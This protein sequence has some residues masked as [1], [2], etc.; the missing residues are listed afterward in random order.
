MEILSN[1]A[2]PYCCLEQGGNSSFAASETRVASISESQ[3]LDMLLVT[4]EG[5]KVTLS[6]D[7]STAA[8]YGEHGQIEAS[9]DG[10][11]VQWTELSTGQYERELQLSIEGDLNDQERCE[12]RKAIQTLGRMLCNFT[13][14]KVRPMESLAHSLGGLETIAQLDV[15][16]AYEQQVLVARQT[17]MAVAYG[18]LGEGIYQPALPVEEAVQAP[19]QNE[20]ED[21]AKEAV[22]A[23]MQIETEN[24]AKAGIQVALQA[25]TK[26]LAKEMAKVVRAVDAPWKDMIRMTKCLF[27]HHCKMAD[28]KESLVAELINNVQEQFRALVSDEEDCRQSC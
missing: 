7:A 5:D 20:T 10:F 19:L 2:T 13:E 18:Q 12:I 8:S 16:M 27:D 21:T 26:K 15:N 9:K 14:G 4:E 24:L 1:T 28:Q 17:D 6:Y 11:G 25:E 22:E 3:S 23:S